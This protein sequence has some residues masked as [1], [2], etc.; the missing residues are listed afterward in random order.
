V[1][2]GTHAQLI[3]VGG[4]DADLYRRQFSAAAAETAGI[5]PAGS[6]AA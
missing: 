1:E 5:H 3:E 2:K 4:P 6:S